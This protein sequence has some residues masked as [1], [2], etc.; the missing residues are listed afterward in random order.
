MPMINAYDEIDEGKQWVYLIEACGQS[1]YKIGMSQDVDKRLDGLQAASFV[2]LRLIHKFEA[3]DSRDAERLLH[4]VFRNKRIR[5]E[6]FSLDNF[7][8]AFVSRIKGFDKS[9]VWDTESRVDIADL[10]IVKPQTYRIMVTGKDID[11]ERLIE[12]SETAIMDFLHHAWRRQ[13]DGKYGLSGRYW[14]RTRKPRMLPIIYNAITKVLI[15]SGIVVNREQKRSGLLL[16]SP[17][18][19]LSHIRKFVVR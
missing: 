17:I 4:A 3:D 18:E 12:L 13:Q 5:N 10:E 7:D 11:G 2:N 1:I 8:L 14:M 16:M 6:W 15:D 19:C 9:F